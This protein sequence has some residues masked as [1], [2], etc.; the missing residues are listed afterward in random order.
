M[1][2]P[3]VFGRPHVYRTKL[4]AACGGGAC[5]TS[6]RR[7]IW[8]VF[9]LQGFRFNFSTKHKIHRNLATGGILMRSIFC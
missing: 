6:I 3:S 9:H 7:S 4:V 1:R 8:A 5:F 2:F